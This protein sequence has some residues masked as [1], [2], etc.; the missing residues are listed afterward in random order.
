MDML[1]VR[2]SRWRGPCRLSSLIPAESRPPVILAANQRLLVP[3]SVN[4]MR[5]TGD[6]PR[7]MY[8][9]PYFFCHRRLIQLV[10]VQAY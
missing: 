2:E 4:R 6:P 5:A 3:S 1:R 8:V 10:A 7:E 9:R